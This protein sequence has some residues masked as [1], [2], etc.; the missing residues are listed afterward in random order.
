MISTD[1]R[2]NQMVHSGVAVVIV[3]LLT[4]LPTKLFEM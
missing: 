3:Q 1:E 2:K 4:K